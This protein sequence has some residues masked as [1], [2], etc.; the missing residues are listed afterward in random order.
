MSL[1]MSV[2]QASG[3]KRPLE[4]PRGH[5]IRWRPAGKL[6]RHENVRTRHHSR[7]VT[8]AVLFT[9][10]V[11]LPADREEKASSRALNMLCHSL[12]GSNTKMSGYHLL[13]SLLTCGSSFFVGMWSFFF[14]PPALCTFPRLYT[15]PPIV[16]SSICMPMMLCYFSFL[17]FL[18][19]IMAGGSHLDRNQT[20][21]ISPSA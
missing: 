15:S 13:S 11:F 18:F 2:G 4:G 3:G 12:L 19:C 5:S 16:I 8:Q 14:P 10:H 1:D 6:R 21:V 7:T 9:S 20:T 17:V